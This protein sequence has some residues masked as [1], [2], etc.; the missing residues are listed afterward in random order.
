M[1][2]DT[3]QTVIISLKESSYAKA[4]ESGNRI[5]PVQ[6]TKAIDLINSQ[7]DRLE[8]YDDAVYP[9]FRRLHNTISIFGGRGSGKTSFLHS[10]INYY[11]TN[12]EDHTSQKRE[13]NKS[14]CVLRIIDPT[15]LEDKGNIFL[16]NYFSDKRCRGRRNTFLGKQLDI[17]IKKDMGKSIGKTSKGHPGS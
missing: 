12:H 2:E 1:R 14:V 15:I 16:Y 9:N 11:T 13:R 10:L 7:I 3:K 5:H 17:C 8:Q 4:F 6:Y